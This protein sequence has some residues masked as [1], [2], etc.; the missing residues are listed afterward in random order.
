MTRQIPKMNRRAFLKGAGSIAISLPFLDMMF[1]ATAAAAEIQVPQRLFTFFFAN[2]CPSELWLPSGRGSNFQFEKALSALEPFRHRLALISGLH[3]P[4]GKEGSGD[5]HS[6][7]S[8]AFAVGVPNPYL[9]SDVFDGSGKRHASSA[10]GPSIEQFALQ[11][12]QPR[13]RLPSLEIGTMR[14]APFSRTYHIKSWRGVNQPNPPL[15]NPLDTFHR[16]FGRPEADINGAEDGRAK[17]YEESILDTVLPEYHRVTSE[18][19]GLS[20]MSR[21]MIGDHM[22]QVRDLERRALH[23]DASMRAQ[24]LAPEEPDSYT[25]TRYSE[26]A[27]IFRLQAELLAMAL[28]CDVTRFGNVMLGAGAESF[29]LTGVDSAHHDLGHQWN[30]SPDNDFIVY[31]RFQMELFAYLLELLDDEA[32]VEANGRTVLENMVLLAGTEISNPSTHDHDE[33][34]YLVAGGGGA[35]RTGYHHRVGDG[36]DRPENDL[37]TACLRAVGVEAQG[38]GSA[39]FNTEPLEL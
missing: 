37:Y 12:V 10:G 33:M 7:G 18:R 39:R 17:R 30:A 27:E 2:G 28:R 32:H 6:R 11:Q 1:P 22:D 23:H 16:I 5:D 34:L 25:E 35:I 38:F 13:T 9:A 26:Y 19:Y 21:T 15:L 36:K 24:C 3:D 29:K 31:T 8:G 14:G 20:G 4:A